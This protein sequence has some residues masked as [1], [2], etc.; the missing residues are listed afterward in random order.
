MQNTVIASKLRRGGGSTFCKSAQDNGFRRTILEY[1]KRF[2]F[3]KSFSFAGAIRK[4]IGL[5][6]D[7]KHCH[8]EFISGSH[9]KEILNSHNSCEPQR[10]SFQND[11]SNDKPFNHSTFHPFNFTAH[12]SSP[13][14][15]P[16]AAFTL[17]EVLITLG[18]IGVVA[19]MTLPTL[20]NNYKEKELITRTKKLYS[21]IQNAIVLAQKDLGVVGDNT[22]LFDVNQTSLQTA[23]KLSKYFNGSKVCENQNQKGCSQ[24]YYSI[25]YATKKTSGG[26]DTTIGTSLTGPK[27]ILNDGSIIQVKQYTSCRRVQENDCVQDA[28]GNC[29]KDE[30]GNTTDKTTIHTYCADLN[31][32]VN[33]TKLP[34]QYGADIYNIQIRQNKVSPSSWAPYGGT[35][36]RNIL[37]GKDKLQYTKYSVGSK[38]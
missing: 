16:K 25:K 9:N 14:T 35:S 18:I 33:G 22:F 28:N 29:V 1:I 8:P 4:A 7:Y 37:T 38:L 19:A 2:D 3:F 11:M 6:K 13:F 15:R 32:D 5:L 24:Y 30:D 36:I 27:I 26:G 21:N 12:H 31:I 23:E 20:V 10:F 17:A 34:N